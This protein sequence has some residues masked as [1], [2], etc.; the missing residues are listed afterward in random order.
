MASPLA[1]AAK[2]LRVSS[3]HCMPKQTP[4][5][6]QRRLSGSVN[7]SS[8]QTSPKP[9]K[10][11]VVL[12]N[13]TLYIDKDL[14]IVLGWNTDS[15]VEGVPLSLHGWDPTFFTIT[16]TGTDNGMLRPFR[17]FR[18]INLHFRMVISRNG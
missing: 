8:G 6:I 10:F 4:F 17:A 12:D 13:G 14:A 7:G 5:R 11:E 1:A 18:K 16:R 15:Q 2:S 3:R 9:R